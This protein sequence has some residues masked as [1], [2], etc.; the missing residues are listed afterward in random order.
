VGRQCSHAEAGG[1]GRVSRLL[2]GSDGGMFVTPPAVPR[3]FCG[4]PGG[5]AAD[6]SGVVA[7][8]SSVGVFGTLR[9]VASPAGAVTAPPFASL[10]VDVASS[11][12][13]SSSGTPTAV[14]DRSR[15]VADNRVVGAV[16]FFASLAV[17]VG[18]PVRFFAGTVVLACAR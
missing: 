7:V 3:A 5:G 8:F 14:W 10:R 18:V 16:L 15:P 6:G 2:N 13:D 12:Q 17:V 11:S 9:T 1:V 4:A